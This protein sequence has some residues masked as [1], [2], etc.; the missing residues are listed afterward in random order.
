MSTYALYGEIVFPEHQGRQGF[1]IRRFNDVKIES[2]WQSLTG[3]AEIT[4]PRRVK[5]FDCMN[6]TEW[7]RESDPVE[8][9]LGYNGNLVSEFTGYL[10]KVPVGI[11]LVLSLEDEMFQL[12]RKTVSVSFQNPTLKELLSAI[13]PGYKIVCD[14]SAILGSVRFSNMAASAILDELKKTGIHSWF[15]GKELHAMNASR[16][17]IAPLEVQLER[18]AGESLK[19]KAIEDTLVV[20]SLLRKVGKKIKVEYG[21]KGAGKRIT[22]ELSGISITEAELLAEAKK[23]YNESKRPGLDGDITLFG[24]PRVVHGM[25]INLKSAIYPEKDGVYYIDSVTKTFSEQGY[26]QQCKLGDKAI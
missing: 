18:T 23:I 3:T 12:K 15:V 25:K 20:I 2:S 11:P 5:D 7:F 19:Q 6:V 14:E 22:R 4:I 13:A 16:I 10:A 21:E 17:D 8:I 1:K 24:L 26:R 9:Y